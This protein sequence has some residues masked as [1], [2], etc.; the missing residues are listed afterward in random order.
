MKLKFNPNLP[1]QQEPVQAA[2]QLFAGQSRA[3]SRFTISTRSFLSSVL[4]DEG[5]GN[6]LTI[7]DVR[8]TDNLR[9]LQMD[10]GLDVS[11]KL[12]S[13]D[14]TIE[15][16]TGTGKTYVYLR[17]IM[18][19]NK[20][21]DFKKF[22][23]VVPGVAIRE[24]VKASLDMLLPHFQS[25]YG[26]KY[27]HFIY[28]SQN[29]GQVAEFARSNSIEIMV[30]NIA[31]FNK[32]F[33]EDGKGGKDLVIH[34]QSEKTG[35]RKPIEL[36]AETN[37]I[38]IIDE[39]QSVDNTKNAKKAMNALN[40]LAT[41]RYSATHREIKN[42]IYELT[43]VDAYNQ[44]LVKQIEVLSI[45]EDED[46]NGSFIKVL[47]TNPAKKTAE[48]E[49]NLKGKTG[50][51]SRVTKTV[52]YKDLLEEVTGNQAYAGLR[53]T[54]LDD[55]SIELNGHERIPIGSIKTESTLYSDDE[56]K[57]I[58]IRETIKTHFERQL[59]LRE[60][61]IK[62]LSLFF[63]DK[64]AN[65]RDYDA[66][67]Q[68]GKYALMFEEEL[69]KLTQNN[70]FYQQLFNEWG[71][72]VDKLHEGYFSTDNKQRA[73][74]TTG[75]TNDDI[76]TYD[77]IMKRKEVLLS[78]KNSYRFIFS[79][80]ALREGWDNPNVFQICMLKDP[81]TKLDKN[82]RLRQEI[83]RGLRIAVNQKGERVFDDGVNILTVT[84]NEVFSDFVDRFQ[85]ELE[86]DEGVNYGKITF[87][88]FKNLTY[89]DEEGTRHVLGERLAKQLIKHLERE[90]LLDKNKPTEKLERT[91][92]TNPIVTLPAESEFIPYREV[93]LNRMDELTHKIEI[94]RHKPPVKIKLNK[95]IRFSEE[96]E[97][98][99]NRI[100]YKSVYSVSFNELSFKNECIRALN[101][102]D[103]RKIVYNIEKASIVIDS[104]AGVQTGGR[105]INDSGALSYSG[106]IR[107]PDVIRYL[108]NET[109]LKRKLLIEILTEST[110]LGKII[111]NPQLYMELVRDVIRKRMQHRLV[112]GIK[113]E[114]L[115]EEYVMELPSDE[116]IEGFFEGKTIEVNKS[117]YD[118]IPVDSI[119]ESE[120]AKELDC[121][122][123]VKCFMKL[124]SSFKID[125]P[126]GT[127]N[128]D[129]AVYVKGV[130]N[131]VYF[132]VETKGTEILEDLKPAEQDKIRCARVHFK[133]IAPEVDF[134]APIKNGKV[135]LNS[136]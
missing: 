47:S 42:P 13:R 104:D 11:E 51:L 45:F 69:H 101:E 77:L 107:I 19:L 10:K 38:V 15:M 83:G 132:V 1:H 78:E 92:Q 63:I 65:Y 91:L 73:K 70:M 50:K 84:A 110:S 26:T 40:A 81:Q 93:I 121:H 55:Y 123:K 67:D 127:Y 99:W 87:D 76:S 34:R 30:I 111:Y 60:K 29:L 114:K 35:G 49:L 56:L 103:V 62:V 21:Y 130:E 68:K 28:D 2:V 97:S 112:D 119:V 58:M 18:E 85:K 23:I 86:E 39:P 46:L 106:K 31:A 20:E 136:L 4:T 128:P 120:F 125:T 17:T 61:G 3:S 134:R 24:G 131:K 37:P 25:L 32:S 90:E 12:G 5:A 74:D 7:S 116:E 118:R 66:H 72:S 54:N 16:E 108:Q 41:F 57:R 44:K 33:E 75:K 82:I 129:W 105:I 98:L 115:G 36:L 71:G 126:L 80:S 96:F 14:F 79:H 133:E 6:R 43:A 53:I 22:I 117:I 8:L 102:L 95:Q 59:I 27:H 89:R 113:Y 94:K 124:P 88:K 64:V 52:K 48:L 109:G 135:F 122:E 100:K 9:A